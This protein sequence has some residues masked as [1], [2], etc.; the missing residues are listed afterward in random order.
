M[1]KIRQGLRFTIEGSA[2]TGEIKKV[3]DKVEVILTPSDGFAY[4]VEWDANETQQRFD[5]GFYK[6]ISRSEFFII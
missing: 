4:V 3:G 5:S 6:V 2:S 1:E